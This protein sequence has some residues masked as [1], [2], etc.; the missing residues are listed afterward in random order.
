M[1]CR[2]ASCFY[3]VVLPAVGHRHFL[4]PDDYSVLHL[5]TVAVPGTP[6]V[7]DTRRGKVLAWAK[8]L[9]N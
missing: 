8:R 3:T 5:E 4:H 1:L 6:N 2:S 9:T 7:M